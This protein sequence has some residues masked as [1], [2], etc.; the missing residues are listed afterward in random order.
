MALLVLA[1]IVA[2]GGGMRVRFGSLRLSVTSPLRLLLWTLALAVARRVVWP[3][4]PIYRDLPRQIAAWWRTAVPDDI[5]FSPAAPV[6]VGLVARLAALFVALTAVMTYPLVWHLGDAVYDA[7][8]PL[9]NLWV[10]RWV[11]HQLPRDPRHLFDANIFAPERH[12]LAFSETLIA[13]AV[14]TAPLAWLG[15]RRVLL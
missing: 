1:A 5:A 12:T 15:A 14:L 9:L 6:T 11:I 8:D 7:G 3:S 13:P 10:I 4:V 2:V